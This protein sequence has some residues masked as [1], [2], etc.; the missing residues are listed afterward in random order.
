[1]KV[2]GRMVVSLL[3]LVLTAPGSYA[4]GRPVEGTG[5]SF[6]LPFSCGGEA[7]DKRKANEVICLADSFKAG[8][9]VVLVS[10]KARC[11]GKTA[12]TFVNEHLGHEF[13]ATYLTG[14]AECLTEVDNTWYEIAVVGVAL[15][16]VHVVEARNDKSPLSQE[17][18]AKARKV[19]KT[20]YKALSA[21]GEHV[22]DVADSAPEVFRAGDAAFLLF[23]CTDEFLNQ[24]GL[25]VLVLNNNAFLLEGSCA[26]RSPFFFTVNNKLH[27]SYGATVA[28]CGCGDSNLFVY[29]LS[30]ESPELVYQNSDFSD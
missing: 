15:S 28:C 2:M 19:A 5:I 4:E 13:D 6:S 3:A 8:L 17:M 16:G 29:D 25:P 18:E 27:V 10:G 12:G 21:P 22:K 11:T 7:G 9:N 26:F 24:D 20:G 1:M 23:K 30:G 14:T